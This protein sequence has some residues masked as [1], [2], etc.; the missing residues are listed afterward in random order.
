MVASL[1][2]YVFP[3]VIK[4]HVACFELISTSDRATPWARGVAVKKPKVEGQKRIDLNFAWG[5]EG[6]KAGQNL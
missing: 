1:N 3:H 5:K 2:G 6:P 4:L